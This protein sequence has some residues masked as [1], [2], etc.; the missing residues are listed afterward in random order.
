MIFHSRSRFQ[1]FIW[2]AVFCLLSI[3]IQAQIP[4][5]PSPPRLVNDL[6]GIFS[7]EQANLLERRLVQFNDTSSTQIAI[8]TLND[9]GGYAVGDLAVRIGEEWGVGQKGFNNGVLVLVKP[10]DGREMGEVFIAT[11]YGLEGVIPDAMARRIVENEMVP[12][13]K[14]GDY[15]GGVNAG[16]EALIKLSSG[17]YKAENP[18][19]SPGIWVVLIVLGIMIIA[20]SIGFSRRSNVH[21]I[22]SEIPWWLLMTMMSGGRGGSSGGWGG[23]TGGGS[24][25][26]FG[27]FGGGS[28]GGGGAGGRW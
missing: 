3:S 26:G 22:G 9:L 2:L 28:F 5:K 17:E 11:G 20:M 10:K 27:G 6:A 23:F 16:V 24:G 15:Y 8:V 7:I 21:T 18:L 19:E 1:L 25:G 14:A 4:A 12:H 13:F